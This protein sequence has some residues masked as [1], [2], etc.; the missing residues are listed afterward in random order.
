M[1]YMTHQTKLQNGDLTVV[2]SIEKV[3]SRRTHSKNSFQEGAVFRGALQASDLVSC[4]VPPSF[5]PVRYATYS[6]IHVLNNLKNN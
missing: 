1:R 4:Q 2:T 3:I 5:L 6:L